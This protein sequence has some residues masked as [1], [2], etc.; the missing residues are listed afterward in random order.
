MLSDLK[1]AKL[2][3]KGKRTNKL[4]VQKHPD[5]DGLYLAVTPAH[6]NN[7]QATYGSKVWRWDFR[8]PPSAKGERFTL[9]Y[10]KYPDLSLAEARAKHIAARKAVANK[11][12]PAK[13]KQAEKQSELKELG[14]TYG[15]VSAKWFEAEKE[16]K[17]KS[18]CDNNERWLKITE[19]RL[20]T[21][22]LASITDDDVTEALK[23]LEDA[24]N[25]YSAA[26]ALQQVSK[27]F[28]FAR[29]KPWR[30]TGTNPT[31][32]LRGQI[33]VPSHKGH[34]HIKEQEIPEFLRAVDA[35]KGAEQT[36]IATRLLMLT[37]VRKQ[38]LLAAKKSELD[39]ERGIFEIPAERMKNKVPHLVPLST[40][41]VQ[42]FKRQLEIAGG[43][44]YV[45]PNVQRP[46]KHAGLSTLN[47]FFNRLGYQD[48]LTPHG[49]RSVA[50]TKLNGTRK[51]SGDVIERQLSHIELNKIRG[52]YNKA[53]WLEIRAEMMQFW[54]DHLD[55]LCKGETA[56]NVVPIQAAV[57]A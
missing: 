44:E 24:G 3:Y 7:P 52:S 31:V 18:W 28:E 46:K 10:G 55:R 12:N 9:T 41:A 20:G 57:A 33:K 19:K 14:N 17:S 32:T 8:F 34:S 56:S 25:A 29:R 22:P 42:L 13:Q 43:G 5:R 30:F 45:F 16:G 40:Q 37:F 1:V 38:E 35:S 6:K 50:S 49:L 2:K 23:P 53:D 39:L 48:R 51:F 47:V 26:R 36:K 15:K 4:R 54:A 21:K 11:I 27:I